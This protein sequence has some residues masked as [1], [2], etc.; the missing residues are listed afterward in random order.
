MPT[1]K[2]PDGKPQVH[3]DPALEITPFTLYRRLRDGRAPVLVDARSEPATPRSLAG[4]LHRPDAGWRPA[5]KDVD[6]VVFDEDGSEAMDWVLELQHEG[7]SRVRL[8]FGGLDLYEFSL[9]PEVVGDETFL[10]GTGLI[11]TG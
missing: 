5:G 10:N 8:L 4:A 3:F 2:R 6:V 11:D 7:Y 1:F 9:D